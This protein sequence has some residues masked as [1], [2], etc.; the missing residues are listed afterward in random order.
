MVR[1]LKKRILKNRKFIGLLI[2]DF[3]EIFCIFL[4]SPEKLWC[5]FVK[6]SHVFLLF[7]IM[8]VEKSFTKIKDV[9]L[10]TATVKCYAIF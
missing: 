5:V 8:I 10:K 2:T 9:F 7:Q 6:N 1:N 3:Y 4:F